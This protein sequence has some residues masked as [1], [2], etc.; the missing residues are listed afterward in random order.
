MITFFFTEIEVKKKKNKPLDRCG[1]T[2]DQIARAI[3]REKVG[4]VT[5]PGF[6]LYCKAVVIKTVWY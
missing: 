2:R 1:T 4:G 5:L 6:K 3:L